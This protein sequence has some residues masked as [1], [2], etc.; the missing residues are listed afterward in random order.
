VKPPAGADAPASK[1]GAPPQDDPKPQ[2][3]PPAEFAQPAPVQPAR[4][5]GARAPRD[6][7][8]VVDVALKRQ[9]DN[10]SLLFPFASA[11][12]AAIFRRA[13]TL[14]LVFDTD[15]AIGLDAF[16]GETSRT[17]KSATLVRYD[18]HAVVRIKLERPR[19]IS[20]TTDGPGW[21]VTLGSEVLEPT[22][23]LAIGRNIL[24]T[25]RASI[26]IP[27]DDPRQLHRLEDP[28]VGDTLLI[29][30][31]VGPARSF[32]KA[33]DFV[34]FRALAA[35]HGV[36]V[37]PI[38]DDL[39][40]ELAVD[41]I[42]VTRPSG[43]T[44]SALLNGG[45]RA[46]SIVY[47][48][49]VLDARV[50]SADRAADFSTR[51]SE[52]IRAAA[53]AKEV[54]RLIARVEL[55]RFYLARDMALEAKAVL[56]VALADH[57]PTAEDPTALVLRGAAN[58]LSGRPAQGLKDLASPLVGNQHDAPLWRALAYAR[59]GKW[60]DAREAFRNLG[61]AMGTLPV[62]LQ[63]L[64]LKEIV[65]GSIEVGDI[66]GA[67]KEMQEFEAIGVPR[68]L[69]PA[70]AVLHGRMAEGLGRVDDA[71]R[72]FAAA[73][74]SSDRPAAAQGRLREIVLKRS[75]GN[76]SRAEAIGELETLS[77]IWRGDETELEALALLARLYTEDS[78]YRDA[79]HIMR[80]ALAAHPNSEITRRV[81]DE[82]AET[83]DHL[84]LGGKADALPA[85]EAL[86]LF[87]DFRDLTPIGRRGD[88]MIRRLADRLVA[89]DLLDQAAELLQHQ[90]D[91]R[92]Q[93]AARA[94]VA[95]RLSVIYL[96]NRKPDRTLATLR[97]TRTAELSNELRNQRIL[98]EARALS[99]MG[100]HDLALEIIADIPGR[101]AVRLRSDILWV[102]RRWR[103]AAEQIELLY[104]EQWRDFAAVT[105]SER[106]DILRAA[107]GYA[108]GEDSI[109]LMRL[110]ERFAG[111]MGEGSER[112]AFDVVTAPIGTS[113][114][115]FGEIARA[116]ASIDTLD[117]FLRDMRER[118]PESGPLPG[119][120]PPAPPPPQTQKPEPATTGSIEPRRG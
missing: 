106:I 69:E 37:Q 64:M 118:Y 51:K 38:A 56:D 71:L 36:V 108:L 21:T 65:R 111:K 98:L 7:K 35:T 44:L 42:V 66:T 76:L 4:S 73:G 33:Q 41:K 46:A 50:W 25:A 101:E 96:T 16:E 82:A 70:L 53:Q 31:A 94:Q 47:Q 45:P 93:G 92:L 115:E 26:T 18:H 19:L 90:V 15:A 30:T 91:H 39:N 34:E 100:R 61:M 59:Q 102:A 72:A 9:G 2:A 99:D 14:W 28:D 87:Y 84:F 74:E 29:V 58:I 77:T 78:R 1:P 119:T 55:A 6:A 120:P 105:A 114:A 110:R 95:T 117:A 57:P 104:G 22:R 81:H 49:Y 68:E 107:I 8:A 24:G 113:G 116:I 20:A 86:S 48:P 12:P 54:K 67:L 10:L 83:F 75:L 79:F 40:A 17:V 89:V 63:R 85:I 88:E 60:N 27:F 52:L 43:L 3:E 97:A 32:V 109:G 62:E 103:E 11:T 112:R 13:D 5:A 80:T 23:P